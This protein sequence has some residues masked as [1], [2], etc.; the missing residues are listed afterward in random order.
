MIIQNGKVLFAKDD[1]L[2]DGICGY[3]AIPH[4]TKYMQVWGPGVKNIIDY[5]I[6]AIKQNLE[7]S[8]VE[9]IKRGLD[10]L[11]ALVKIMAEQI[12]P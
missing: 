11:K 9:E 5:Q 10:N 6:E 1:K 2:F 3:K 12:N 8:P 7:I 4:D